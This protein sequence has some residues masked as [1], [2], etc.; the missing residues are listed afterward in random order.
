M[1]HEYRGCLLGPGFIPGYSTDSRDWCIIHM[2]WC[3]FKSKVFSHATLFPQ[4]PHSG[5]LLF[6]E[7]AILSVHYAAFRLWQ[8]KEC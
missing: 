8:S 7:G 1:L 6:L 4:S 2:C 5:S 3:Q